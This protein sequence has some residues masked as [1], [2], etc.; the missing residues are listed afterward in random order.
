M[1][2]SA[3]ADDMRRVRQAVR[4]VRPQVLAG[5]LRNVLAGDYGRKRINASTRVVAIFAEQDR[6]LGRR[7][8][9]TVMEVCPHA[10]LENIAAP[11]LALQAEPKAV[12]DLLQRL[13]VLA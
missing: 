7:A 9:Q 4:Q 2:G 1:G 5:R 12:V 6:L 8:R 13:G 10:E 11:H 3:A